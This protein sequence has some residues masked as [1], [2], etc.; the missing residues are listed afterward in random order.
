MVML[1]GI[2][3]LLCMAR[4]LTAFF[5]IGAGLALGAAAGCGAMACI[6]MGSAEGVGVRGSLG[7]RQIFQMQTQM[8]NVQM[9]APIMAARDVKDQ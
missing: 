1:I 6:G 7:Q 2:A 4:V 9:A 8:V 5:Y 3:L